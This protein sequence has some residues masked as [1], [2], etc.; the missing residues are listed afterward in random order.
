MPKLKYEQIADHLR[1]R[2]TEGDFAP[3]DVVPS[4]RDL[5]EQFGVSRATVIKAM[6]VL[7]N[8]GVVV[9]KQ[10]SG[11]TVI[12]TPVA[13]PAGR[14]KSGSRIAGGRPY[15]RLGAPTR[16]VPPHRVRDALQL[17]P[18]ERAL[19]RARL[20]LDDEG[21]PFSFVVAWFPL[22]IADACP[23]LSQ[24]GPIA[25]GTTNYVARTT[26]RSPVRGTDVAQVR[27]A[28]EAEAVQLGLSLP[29]AVAV[30]RHTAYDVAGCPLVCEEGVTSGELWEHSESYSMGS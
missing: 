24:K 25:E 30:D 21:C 9:A 23:R 7:R 11:F 2:I 26:N 20:V 5:C 16:E 13:R 14:R 17:P 28:T 10:G 27:L 1:A 3:G 19:H 29:A 12:E 8:D 15:K 4:G 6:D 22:D 18:G